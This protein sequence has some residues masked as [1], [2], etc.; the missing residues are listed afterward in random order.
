MKKLSVFLFVI[1]LSTVVKA[2][3][4]NLILNDNND[5]DTLSFKRGAWIFIPTWDNNGRLFYM[6]AA[7]N[8]PRIQD[9]V[10]IVESLT[11]PGI[12]IPLSENLRFYQNSDKL[13]FISFCEAAGAFVQQNDIGDVVINNDL[14]N[15][16][17]LYPS[18]YEDALTKAELIDRYQELL[19]LGL[20]WPI[21]YPTSNTPIYEGCN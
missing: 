16:F 12:Y 2:Q 7:L 9:L 17:D 18:V 19:D 11:T 6:P 4:P 10:C 15:I 20:I 21:P 8:N 13:D 5:Y 3:I 14:Y 1:L